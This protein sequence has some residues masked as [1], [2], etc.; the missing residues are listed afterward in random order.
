M[1]PE[2]KSFN[3]PDEVRTPPNTRM[4]FVKFGDMTLV[5]MIAQPGWRWSQD[6]GPQ[7]GTGSCQATHAAVVVSGRLRVRAD[8]GEELDLGPGDAHLVGPGH[9]AWVIGDEPCV[10]VDING[11]PTASLEAPCPCGVTFR[12]ASDAALDHLVAAVQE[13]ARASH[14]Q[15]VAREHL[16]AEL[17]LPASAGLSR[18]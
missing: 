4:E 13:H 18:G 3:A 15:E 14:D 8:D 9:D 11:T 1:T 5:R 2:V 16:L 6:V 10:T 7:A 17:G 12:I